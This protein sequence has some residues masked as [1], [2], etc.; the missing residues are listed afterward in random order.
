[1]M[2]NTYNIV[3]IYYYKICQNVIDKCRTL[4][5]VYNLYTFLCYYKMLYKKSFILFNFDITF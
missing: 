3:K 4:S 2:K 5:L 1:M